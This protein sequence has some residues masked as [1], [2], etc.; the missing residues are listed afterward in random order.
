MRKH[1]KFLVFYTL[2]LSAI[3]VTFMVFAEESPEVNLQPDTEICKLAKDNVAPTRTKAYENKEC[4]RT[5]AF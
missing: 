4:N 5:Q 2:W 1:R 3:M